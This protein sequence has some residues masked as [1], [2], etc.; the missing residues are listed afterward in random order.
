MFN[1]VTSSVRWKPLLSPFYSKGIQAPGELVFCRVT[2]LGIVALRSE[3]LTRAE[4]G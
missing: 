2:Q 1:A 4:Q 3:E